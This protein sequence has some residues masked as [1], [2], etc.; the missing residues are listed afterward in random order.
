MVVV[1]KASH[2]RFH[3]SKSLELFYIL[4][5]VKIMIH[6]RFEEILRCI[7]LVNNKN[8]LKNKVDPT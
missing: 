6:Y 2:K 4:A 8:V 1:K 5:I 3:W 7:H